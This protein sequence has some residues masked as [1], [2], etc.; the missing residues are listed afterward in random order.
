MVKFLAYARSK[1]AGSDVCIKWAMSPSGVVHDGLIV[2]ASGDTMRK[3]RLRVADFS[4]KTRTNVLNLY[5]GEA[6]KIVQSGELVAVL[7]ALRV[8]GC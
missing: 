8:F 4:D 6:F 5:E 1:A 7:E 2:N 3:Y